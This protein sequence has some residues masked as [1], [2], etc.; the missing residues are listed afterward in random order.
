MSKRRRTTSLTPKPSSNTRRVSMLVE[1]LEPRCMFAADAA[2]SVEP[3]MLVEDVA[4]LEARP[5]P[6]PED[7]APTLDGAIDPIDQGSDDGDFAW[8]AMWKDLTPWFPT[9]DEMPSFDEVA[10]DDE[11]AALGDAWMPL[12]YWRSG[13]GGEFTDWTTADSVDFSYC[14]DGFSQPI[15]PVAYAAAGLFGDHVGDQPFG[16]GSDWDNT[17]D[18]TVTSIDV[19][20]GVNLGYWAT[21]F[22]GGTFVPGPFDDVTSLGGPAGDA[23][24]PVIAE[25]R[26]ASQVVG[27]EPVSAAAGSPDDAK[28]RAAAFAVFANSQGSYAGLGSAALGGSAS[29]G[30]ASGDAGFGV[31]RR[32]RR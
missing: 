2:A 16:P 23:Q 31:R 7:S 17:F 4:V 26:F 12:P 14:G 27:G 25:P 24:P 28:P 8:D 30:D 18:V 11:V 15:Y 3:V 20:D 5:L 6:T 22:G 19:A 32:V 13:T 29:S 21:D 10:F 9:G 1:M